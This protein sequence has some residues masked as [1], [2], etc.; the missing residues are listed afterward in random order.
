MS[1]KTPQN[2]AKEIE[3]K[4][5]FEP[6]HAEILLG[7]S[8]FSSGDGATPVP[9]RRVL[10][11][12]ERHLDSTYYDTPDDHLRKAGVFLRVRRTGHGFVQTI[13]TGRALSE[14]LER[15]EWEC[16]LASDTPNLAFAEGTALAPLLTNDVRASLAPRFA[17]RFHRQTFLIDDSGTLIEAAIDRGDIVAGE[18][19]S[20]VCELELELKSGE[21]TALFSLA[22]HLAE[23]VPL[24]LSI[25]TK[26]ERGFDLLD[27]GEPQFEKALPVHISPEQT[28]ATAFRIVARNCMRQIIVN[29]PG[30]RA[31]HAE[32]LHQ[33]RVGLRRLRA[34]ITLFGDVVDGPDRRD[35]AAE[36]KWIAGQLGPARDLDVF[37][38]DVLEPQLATYPND[39]GWTALDTRVRRLRAG[40]YDQAIDATRSRRFRMALLD[41]GAWVE[42]GDW[43]GPENPRAQEPV[44]RLAGAQLSH[45]RRKIIE[46]G[47]G[48]KKLSVSQRHRLRIL[49]KRMRYGSEFFCATFEGKK[50]AKRR[51]RSLPAL[52]RLQDSL[53][54]LNDIATRKSVLDESVLEKSV[55]D[56]TGLGAG[57]AGLDIPAWQCPKAEAKFAKELMKTAKHAYARFADTEEF[58]KT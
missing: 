55:L 43:A 36:A 10:E 16:D 46:K 50:S 39:P 11:T 32:A 9:G 25:K 33:M 48:I 6:Q 38:S 3:L 13:K 35:I 47:K 58:W 52:E 2:D 15:D 45:L 22:K 49:A 34:A 44:T 31:G 19:S 17:T 4:L 26:A 24:T 40:A 7:H 12:K 18:N 14:F 54:T 29:L 1:A 37:I 51:S 30:T 42:F 53:G 8:V 21:S 5:G 23:S 20:M 57:S 56:K 41:L 28:C 27:N